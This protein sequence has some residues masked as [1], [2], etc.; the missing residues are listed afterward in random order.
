[1]TSR[2]T[3][4]LAALAGALALTGAAESASAARHGNEVYRGTP[5]N[6]SLV[7]TFWR[8]YVRPR[9]TVAWR[10]YR[11]V[12]AEGGGPPQTKPVG[13]VV[14][15]WPGVHWSQQDWRVYR[16][17]TI[18]PNTLV[19]RT[20]PIDPWHWVIY[21]RLNQ[22]VAS[23]NIGSKPRWLV[24]R[25]RFGVGWV[26]AYGSGGLPAGAALLLLLGEEIAPAALVSPD[27]R[28]ESRQSCL[29]PRGSGLLGSALVP[30]GAEGGSN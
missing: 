25:G 19:G 30:C 18:G 11:Y 14:L 8:V 16:G 27:R 22:R 10:V 28:R 13:H 2:W 20:S 5:P 3:V 15:P 26:D 6:G 4:L 24:S 29:P 12:P 17:L 23:V 9:G 21:N 1:M 7:G